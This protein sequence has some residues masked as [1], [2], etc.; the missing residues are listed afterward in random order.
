MVQQA[1]GFTKPNSL[2]SIPRVHMEQRENLHKCAVLWSV[3]TCTQTQKR[4]EEEKEVQV[5]KKYSNI[6]FE[7]LFNQLSISVY[8]L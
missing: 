8:L 7:I 5:R 2:S 6:Y 1:K 3:R 4:K